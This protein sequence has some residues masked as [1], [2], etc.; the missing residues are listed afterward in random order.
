MKIFHRLYTLLLVIALS[1]QTVLVSAGPLVP[2][3]SDTMTMKMSQHTLSE[4]PVIEDHQAMLHYQQAKNDTSCEQ[5]HH[6]ESHSS[7]GEC[8]GDD[9][10]C[11]PQACHGSS[12]FL[13]NSIDLVTSGPYS[14]HYYVASGMV[15]KSSSSLFRPPIV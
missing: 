13:L 3:A 8:C 2:A 12:L 4:Q 9:C 15:R 1:L 6:A 7:S 14:E 11:L 5:H 10:S